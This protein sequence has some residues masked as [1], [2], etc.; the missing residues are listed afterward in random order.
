MPH[1]IPTP[2]TPTPA[3]RKSSA[4]IPAAKPAGATGT[5]GPVKAAAPKKSPAASNYPMDPTKVPG[6][7]FGGGTL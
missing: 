2:G 4:A 7:K 3:V 1:R 6:F 5:R